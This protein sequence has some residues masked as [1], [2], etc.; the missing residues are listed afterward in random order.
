VF[1]SGGDGDQQ[2]AYSAVL[3]AVEDGE[4]PR[5]RLDEAVRRVLEAKQD[6]GLIG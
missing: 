5:R 2:A 3:R 1:V 6:Y 4:L